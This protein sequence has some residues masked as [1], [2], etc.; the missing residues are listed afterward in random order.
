MQI[1]QILDH[2]YL[3]TR[4]ADDQPIPIPSRRLSSKI[5][6]P[7]P[8]T[9]VDDLCFLAYLKRSFFLCESRKKVEDQLYNKERT[10]EKRWATMLH[11]WEQRVEMEWEDVPT[12]R[13]TP[14]R[15]WYSGLENATEH[16]QG[17]HEDADTSQR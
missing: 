10:W 15:K 11:G 8:Q 7:V 9:V 3:R 12:L 4:A 13:V 16:H 17:H 1:A 14:G 6:R 5:V 2:R